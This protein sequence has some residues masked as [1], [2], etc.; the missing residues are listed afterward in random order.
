MKNTEHANPSNVNHSDEGLRFRWGHVNINVA[1]LDRSIAFYEMLGFEMFLPDIPYLALNRDEPA[2]EITTTAASALELPAGLS[3]RGCI[4]QL[5]GDASPKIDLTE[6]GTDDDLGNRV[7]LLGNSD[8]GL[9]RLCL[10]SRDVAAAYATL[11]SQG[12]EFISAPMPGE[13]GMVTLATCKD[14]DGTLIELLEIHHERW[15][16]GNGEGVR[17]VKLPQADDGETADFGSKN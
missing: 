8:L 15:P 2:T 5:V 14:P 1:N 6:F 9:V 16:D 3:G 13:N 7:T 10:L 11:T 4:M 12:V 17:E